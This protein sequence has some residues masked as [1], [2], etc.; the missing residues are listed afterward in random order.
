MRDG[1]QELCVVS[2]LENLVEGNR[3]GKV[4]NVHQKQKGAQNAPLG[5]ARHEREQ[6]RGVT[7]DT[8]KV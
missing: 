6:V 2:K 1:L 7:I 3:A 8:N 4:V 5:Y